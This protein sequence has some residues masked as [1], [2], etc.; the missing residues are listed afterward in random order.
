MGYFGLDKKKNSKWQYGK[1]GINLKKKWGAALKMWESEKKI[2][3]CRIEYVF[4]FIAIANKYFI[5]NLF[6]SYVQWKAIRKTFIR[7]G[8]KNYVCNN[9]LIQKYF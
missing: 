5:E 1:C 9:N 3:L 7:F 8:D 6:F 4:F 2:K